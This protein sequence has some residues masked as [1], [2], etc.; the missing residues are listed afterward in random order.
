M[1]V[2]PSCH[3]DCGK[4]AFN[5]EGNYEV[6]FGNDPVGKV[7]VLRQGLY[8][9]FICRCKLTGDVVCRLSVCCGDRQENL[10]VLVPTDD[11]FGLDRKVPVKHLG[12]G[13][14][15][16][17]LAPKHD[18][19]MGKFVPISPEEPFSYI[20]RLKDSFLVRQGGQAGIILQKEAGD[21]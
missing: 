10:G 13:K 1:N 21:G 16:F 3:I 7:Q 2:M 4:G 17:L 18:H 11:G 6:R 19:V 9:R 15:D 14:P 12:E 5:L 20:G 8:Y